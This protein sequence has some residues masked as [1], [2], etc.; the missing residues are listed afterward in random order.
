MMFLKRDQKVNITMQNKV[1]DWE[2]LNRK[3]KKGIDNNLKIIF[4][5]YAQLQ[6]FFV[7]YVGVKILVVSYS[8]IGKKSRAMNQSKIVITLFK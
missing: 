3:V 6:R 5:K 7:H 1:K 2:E 8:D 4:I